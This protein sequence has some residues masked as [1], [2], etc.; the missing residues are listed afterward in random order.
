MPRPPNL[1]APSCP[2]CNHPRMH[3]NGDR[4]RCPVCRKQVAKSGATPGGYRH[5]TPGGTTSTERNRRRRERLNMRTKMSKNKFPLPW[6]LDVWR[7]QSQAQYLIRIKSFDGDEVL[8]PV[9]FT[10]EVRDRY[11]A[12]CDA[13]ESPDQQTA[14]EGYQRSLDY[15]LAETERVRSHFQREC[16]ERDA[17]I[18]SLQNEIEPKEK[19]GRKN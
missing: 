14:I 2:Q 18:Q 16:A 13:L 5:G 12:I 4:W 1:A 15:A 11:Q 19:R 8:P 3:S 6:S 17:L 7:P 10:P 9:E